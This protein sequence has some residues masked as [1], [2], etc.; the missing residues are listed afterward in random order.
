MTVELDSG[1]RS[2]QKLDGENEDLTLILR[3]KMADR[4]RTL[5]VNLQGSRSSNYTI[6]AMVQ[7]SN[8]FFSETT[9]MIK[10]KLVQC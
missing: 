6:T 4:I 5:S 1:I 10:A 9:N 7:C 8:A 3:K 2:L